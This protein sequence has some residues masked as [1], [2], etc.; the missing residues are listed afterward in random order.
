MVLVNRNS[1]DYKNHSKSLLLIPELVNSDFL[2]KS[3]AQMPITTLLRVK[4]MEE[5]KKKVRVAKKSQLIKKIRELVSTNLPTGYPPHPLVLGPSCQIYLQLTLLL[6]EESKFCSLEISI[7][8][9]LL[10]HIISNKKSVRSI[11]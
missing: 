2:V 11:T 10:I 8:R 3:E 1:I 4:P 7:R 6:A 9:F 5:V